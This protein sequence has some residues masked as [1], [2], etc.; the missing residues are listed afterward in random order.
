MA[1]VQSYKSKVLNLYSADELQQFKIVPGGDKVQFEYKQGTNDK[2]VDFHKLSVE[3]VDVHTKMFD[4]EQKTADEKARAQG[5]EA[6]LQ[7]DLDAEIKRAGDAEQA[8][9]TA[10]DVEKARVQAQEANEQAALQA[11]VLARETKDLQIDQAISNEAS[12][13][14]AADSVHTQAIVDEQTRAQGEEKKIDDKFEAYKTANDS[15]ATSDE[16]EFVSYK[17][18]NDSKLDDHIA[19]F[20]SQKLK[21]VA[22]NLQ[23]KARAET[24]EQGLQSQITSILSNTDPASLDSLSEI[25]SKFNADGVTYANRLTALESVV[26][27]LVEQLN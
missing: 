9:Q 2:F 5:I 8:I 20:D 16:Q 19:A 24:A 6:G 11:E 4:N 7:T 15:R 18:S 25:V 14:A 10:L 17:N 22:D 12:T 23:E 21:Q 27:A 26:Q 3:D 13:R 1:A